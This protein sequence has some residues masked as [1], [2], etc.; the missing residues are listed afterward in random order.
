METDAH[1]QAVDTRPSFSSHTAWVRGYHVLVPV[2][3]IR[4]LFCIRLDTQLCWS[5]TVYRIIF[6]GGNFREKLEEASRI[7]FCGFKF[8]G[9]IVYFWSRR[10]NEFWIG[11]T[12]SNGRCGTATPA[13]IAFSKPD[14]PRWGWLARLDSTLKPSILFHQNR[15]PCRAAR[16][17]RKLGSGLR[18]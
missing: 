11:M 8:R 7:K 16:A 2:C 10:R 1:A 6:V 15:S 9:A 13:Q 14:Y 4:N 12:E 18:D 3:M 5:I 17:E